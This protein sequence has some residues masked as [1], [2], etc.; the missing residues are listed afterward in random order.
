MIFS[1][2]R[3]GDTMTCKSLDLIQHF[4]RELLTV[5]KLKIKEESTNEAY[6]KIAISWLDCKKLWII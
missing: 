4:Y 3:K 1:P 5:Q 2:R 6:L